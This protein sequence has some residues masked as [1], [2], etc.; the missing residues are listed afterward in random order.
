M[1][2]VRRY[3]I[4]GVLLRSFC[5]S[6]EGPLRNSA[7]ALMTGRLRHC[8]LSVGR[9]CRPH[10]LSHFRKDQV[11][12]AAHSKPSPRAHPS[13]CQPP[14][15]HSSLLFLRAPFAPKNKSQLPLPNAKTVRVVHILVEIRHGRAVVH[16]VII[17]MIDR[18]LTK[19]TINGGN[20]EDSSDQ[21]EQPGG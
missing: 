1:G 18:I 19:V 11:K 15:R 4:H 6:R 14:D 12:L 9:S 17:F 21:R 16:H 7:S 13:L 20:Y 10:P 2:S 3:R 5:R 8:G